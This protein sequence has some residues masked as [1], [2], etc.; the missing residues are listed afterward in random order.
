M[1]RV[2]VAE[3]AQPSAGAHEKRK[4]SNRSRDLFLRAPSVKLMHSTTFDRACCLKAQHTC[5]L[6]NTWPIVMSIYDDQKCYTVSWG[7]SCTVL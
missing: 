4:T 6:I 1:A 7:A 5:D 3:E 2:T